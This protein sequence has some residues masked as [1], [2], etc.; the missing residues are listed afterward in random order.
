LCELSSPPSHNR[1]CTSSQFRI[2]AVTVS[3]FIQIHALV[4]AQSKKEDFFARVLPGK[5]RLSS[6]SCGEKFFQS[7]WR[8]KSY[9]LGIF[10]E[11]CGKRLR[12]G[13]QHGMRVHTESQI[14]LTRPVFEVVPRFPPFTREIRD[15]ILPPSDCFQSPASFEIEIR[16][17]VLFG[18][19]MRVVIG[20]LRQSLPDPG[21]NHHPLR[22]C[23]ANV[24]HAGR[25]HLVK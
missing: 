2:E 25:N 9:C 1:Q 17:G 24:R 5:L 18:N 7:V 22:A 13:F 21:A 6:G 10:F 3:H 4:Q 11:G 15:F 23:N 12:I 14:G 20:C 8:R 16:R 19:E